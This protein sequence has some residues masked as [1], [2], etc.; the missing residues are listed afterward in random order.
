MPWNDSPYR[1]SHTVARLA[2][3]EDAH[4]PR[5]RLVAWLAKH[6]PDYPEAVAIAN[7]AWGTAHS[8]EAAHAFAFER[9]AAAA[10]KALDRRFQEEP[11]WA[12]VPPGG[13]NAYLFDWV[14]CFD[15][16][17][18]PD[19]DYRRPARDR[20]PDPGPPP[21]A[22]VRAEDQPALPGGVGA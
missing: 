10:C 2:G 4:S 14:S 5:Q 1:I 17:H 21:S 11:G 6:Y 18:E 16:D 9:Y 12:N 13:F 3:E 20:L 7:Q 8:E 22:A 15:A 19:S